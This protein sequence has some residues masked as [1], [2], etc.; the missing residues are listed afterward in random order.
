MEVCRETIQTP[1]LN[2]SGV[3]LGECVDFHF[4]IVDAFLLYSDKW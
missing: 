1:L 4:I 3:C 2:L